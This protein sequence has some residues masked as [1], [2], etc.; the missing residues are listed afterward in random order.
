MGGRGAS[1]GIDGNQ[2]TIWH[3]EDKKKVE[4][5]VRN[6]DVIR[7]SLGIEEIKAG[8]F[9]KTYRR[10]FCCGKFTVPLDSVNAKCPVCGWIDDE[11]QNTHIYSTEGANG[12]CL[13]ETRRLY[14]KS[15]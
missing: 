7:D 12:L 8:K 5:I 15:P 11:H 13:A 2:I 4:E 10:C 9:H 6:A 3:Y 1:S 14:L